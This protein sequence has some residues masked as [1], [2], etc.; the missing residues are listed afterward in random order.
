[1][2]QWLLSVPRSRQTPA[3]LVSPEPQETAQVPLAQTCPAA[4][5][6]PHMPQLALSLMRSRQAPE[7]SVRP[8]PQVT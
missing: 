4:Q 3:Q 2:P 1:M 5:A 7:Q 8:E 6:R